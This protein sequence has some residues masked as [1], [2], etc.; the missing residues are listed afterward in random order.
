MA[1]ENSAQLGIS[2]PCYDGPFDL[3]L[4]LIRRQEYPIDALPVLDITSPFL[5]Y[6]NAARELG[7]ELGGE[8]VEVAS[9]LVLLKSRD[10][11]ILR[12][13]GLLA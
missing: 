8:F 4:A 12:Y 10:T 13:R 2:F 9:W 1:E 5:A 6:V 7:A 11:R 3:L